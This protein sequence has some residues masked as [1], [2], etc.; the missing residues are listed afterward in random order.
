MIL[1]GDRVG[2]GLSGG[3]DSLTLLSGLSALRSYYPHP[4]ELIALS[5][6]LGFSLPMPHEVL[7]NFC[8]SLGVPY[9][10]LR[11]DISTIVFELRKESNPCALCSHMRRGALNALAVEHCCNKVALGHHLD[12]AVETFFMNLMYEGRLGC[13]QPVTYLSK[14]NI[15]VIRPLLYVEESDISTFARNNNLPVV[16]NPCCANGNTK[17]SEVKS[18]LLT[19]EQE[20][21]HLRQHTFRALQQSKL[22]GW[23]IETKGSA[24]FPLRD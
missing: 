10:I 20:V 19:L 17:R 9:Y 24:E 15:T 16:V 2:V 12:D 18:L 6:D 13:F 8:D 14:S 4:F 23:T 3:K 21:R 11:T 7:K 5:L 1:P 22:A